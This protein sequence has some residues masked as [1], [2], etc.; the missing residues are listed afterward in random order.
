[1]YYD[2]YCNEKMLL[3]NWD[4]ASGSNRA[5]RRLLGMSGQAP[6]VCA[7][8]YLEKMD[9][10][11][12]L[13]HDRYDVIRDFERIR[14]DKCELL[15]ITSLPIYEQDIRY[16]KEAIKNYK[17]TQKEELVLFGT[18]MMCRILKTNT[19]DL[20]TRYKLRRFCGCFD[21]HVNKVRVDTGKWYD[22]YHEP[23]GMQRLCNEYDLLIRTKAEAGPD[24]IG[25]YYT[26]LNYELTD[27]KIAD[28][29]VVTKDTNRLNL[30]DVYCKA[31]LENLH[32][33][34]R[35]GKEYKLK[36]KTTLYC[37]ECVKSTKREQTRARVKRYRAKKKQ[38]M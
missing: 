3:E 8:M 37:K 9:N 4:S 11:K 14:S 38:T 34:Q 21:G 36:S 29:Y 12:N 32:F 15:E 7:D 13:Y 24:K 17:L 6:D 25:C 28:N 33:C 26:Y 16:I 35:C 23:D 20:T 31:G 5:L 1:M 22:V 19:L 18:I 10:H 2:F 27:K 30:Y